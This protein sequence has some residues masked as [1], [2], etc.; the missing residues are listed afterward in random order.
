MTHNDVARRTSA[1]PTRPVTPRA[2]AC[3]GTAPLET[4]RPL[5]RDLP[6]RALVRPLPS[7]RLSRDE[8]D[9]A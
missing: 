3:D 7:R 4:S 9:A 6:L 1:T 5:T 8:R 2:A